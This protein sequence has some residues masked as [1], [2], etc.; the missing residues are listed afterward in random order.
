METSSDGIPI[1]ADGCKLD[2]GKAP[3]FTGLLEYFPRALRAVAEVSAAG[4]RKGYAPMSWRAVPGGFKRYSDA[5]LRHVLKEAMGT[6]DDTD[7]G[8]TGLPH[9]ALAAWNALARLELMLRGEEK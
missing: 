3:V 9:A 6:C 2:K 5:L 7:E 1:G 8:G 4:I